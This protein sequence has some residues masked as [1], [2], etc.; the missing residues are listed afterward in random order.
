MKIKNLL[1]KIILSLIAYFGFTGNLFAQAA[2]PNP[3]SITITSPLVIKDIPSF[4]NRISGLLIPIAIIGFVGAIIY[5][6]YIRLT[7]NGSSDLEKKSMQTIKSAII[8]F[9]IIFFSGLIMAA[10]ATSIGLPTS[11]YK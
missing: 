9:L 10:V 3:N 6:G 2:T 1:S 5:A 11:S 8:G 7:S 4:V